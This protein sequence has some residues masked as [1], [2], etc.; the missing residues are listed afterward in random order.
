MRDQEW[1]GVKATPKR[2]IEE[3]METP[4]HLKQDFSSPDQAADENVVPVSYPARHLLKSTSDDCSD[5]KQIALVLVENQRIIQGLAVERREL[6]ERLRVETS[7]ATEY[8]RQVGDLKAEN[9]QMIAKEAAL[10]RSVDDLEESLK[11]AEATRMASVKENASLAAELASLRATLDAK[12]QELRKYKEKTES[13]KG[14]LRGAKEELQRREKEESHI[15][16][17]HEQQVSAYKREQVEE[18]SVLQHELSEQQRVCAAAKQT[19]KR[20]EAEL[21]AE[22]QRQ[23]AL[24]DDRVALRTRMVTMGIAIPRYPILPWLLAFFMGVLLS[25]LPWYAAQ[26]NTP[27]VY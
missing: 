21:E 10:K 9:D 24:H 26:A 27:L 15:E 20:L 11:R 16:D 2:L 13:V 18:L 12:K 14:S 17:S 3:V 19:I 7:K 4:L 25:Y 8:Q 5:S 22:R 1:K 6:G 23:A